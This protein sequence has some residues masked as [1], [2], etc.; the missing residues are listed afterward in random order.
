[1]SA[2]R[3]DEG[4]SMSTDLDHE[5][6]LKRI[7][8]EASL[9]RDALQFTKEY[10]IFMLRSCLILNGGAILALLG[11]LGTLHG[12]QT[13]SLHPPMREFVGAFYL[14]GIGLVSATLASFF[15]YLNFLW[16]QRRLS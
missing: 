15:G 1:M 16:S 10:G 14:F 12:R 9:R 13:P 7:D 6:A 3:Q 4:S 2:N 11:L 5:L 8:H